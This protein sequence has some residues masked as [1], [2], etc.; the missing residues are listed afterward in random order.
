MREVHSPELGFPPLHAML[1]LH[2]MGPRHSRTPRSAGWC[3]GHSFRDGGQ[4]EGQAITDILYDI[5]GGWE[6]LLNLFHQQYLGACLHAYMFKVCIPMRAVYEVRVYFRYIHTHTAQ[7]KKEVRL[8][9][10]FNKQLQQKCIHIK[11]L[12]FP[13]R[14]A[15]QRSLTRYIY[16]YVY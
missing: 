1:A 16:I 4:A 9:N 11:H 5:K 6:V 14:V 8:S 12:T 3:A 13:E 2:G 7:W 15:A 10:M